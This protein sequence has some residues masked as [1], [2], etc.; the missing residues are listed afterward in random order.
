VNSGVNFR[1]GASRTARE[2]RA[3]SFASAAL[4]R[5]MGLWKPTF[6]LTSEFISLA[7]RLLVRKTMAAEKSALLLSPNVRTP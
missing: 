5:G 3:L 7:P 2:I 4:S 1:R 6:G